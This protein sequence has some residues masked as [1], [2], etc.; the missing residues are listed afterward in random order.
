V[1]GEAGFGAYAPERR[2]ALA[3]AQ[4]LSPWATLH[5][6]AGRERA[7]AAGSVRFA[8]ARL[9]LQWQRDTPSAAP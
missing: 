6:E 5:F 1:A 9:Q 7:G 4:T 3:W 8:A 2:S